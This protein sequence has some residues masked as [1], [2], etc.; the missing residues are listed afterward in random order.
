MWG[1]SVARKLTD[2]QKTFIREL[3]K[4]LSR[5]AAARAAG[6]SAPAEDAYKL[7]RLPHVRDELHQRRAAWIHGDLSTVAMRTMRDLMIEAPAAQRYQAA[8]WV[9]EQAGH[10]D[11]DADKDAADRPLDE[12]GPEDL[13]RAVQS[14]MESLR[15][16]AGSLDGV[17]IVDG[18]ARTLR[19]IEGELVSEQEDDD[20]TSGAPPNDLD[21]LE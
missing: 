18:E 17:Q 7:M 9:L 15:Q 12:L 14:G 20:T 3:V 6:Y 13:A 4:G 16:L 11:G 8:R 10:R 19:T 5:S 2:K 1:W 21:F